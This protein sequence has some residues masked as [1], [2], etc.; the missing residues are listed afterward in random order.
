MQVLGAWEPVPMAVAGLPCGPGLLSL[1]MSSFSPERNP[2]ES[3]YTQGLP[4]FQLHKDKLSS[5]TWCWLVEKIHN[6]ALPCC[7]PTPSLGR[8]SHCPRNS[9]CGLPCPVLCV[10][11]DGLTGLQHTV[12][13]A[14]RQPAGLSRN[15][16]LLR[17]QG[18]SQ[19]PTAPV[20]PLRK[21]SLGLLRPQARH[22]SVWWCR[23]GW[24]RPQ[25]AGGGWGR[26]RLCYCPGWWGPCRRR[27]LAT[28]RCTCRMGAPR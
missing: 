11:A 8:L 13:G 14:T 10:P 3:V 19:V 15:R 16:D 24:W 23:A 21:P 2:E 1:P 5:S 7:L 18:P 6:P 17:T 26:L 28:T 20:S 22:S 9:P 25:R 12:E 27:P 4:H